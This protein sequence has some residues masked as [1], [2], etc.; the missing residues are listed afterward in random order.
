MYFRQATSV[1]TSVPK[2]GSPNVTQEHLPGRKSDALH[3]LGLAWVMLDSEICSLKNHGWCK[4]ELSGDGWCDFPRVGVL[5]HK[6]KRD[7]NQRLLAKGYHALAPGH[8]L[9]LRICGAGPKFLNKCVSTPNSHQY[10]NWRCP[11]TL[12]R[13]PASY[14]LGIVLR[15]E[16]AVFAAQRRSH[17]LCERYL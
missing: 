8:H 4:A 10:R 3:A 14:A 2:S 11:Q 5:A 16:Q 7:R 13:A 12:H 9:T 17:P 6:R 1:P 15:S